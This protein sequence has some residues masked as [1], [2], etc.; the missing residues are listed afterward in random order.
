MF[1]PITMRTKWFSAYF[2][3]QFSVPT[4]VAGCMVGWSQNLV[5]NQKR[6]NWSEQILK[7]QEMMHDISLIFDEIK[8]KMVRILSVNLVCLWI[9]N[10]KYFQFKIKYCNLNFD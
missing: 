4:A 3:L 2:K 8:T 7:S 6:M 10:F 1:L 5:L 9:S